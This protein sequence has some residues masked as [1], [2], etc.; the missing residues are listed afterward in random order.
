MQLRFETFNAFNHTNLLDKNIGATVTGSFAFA[1]PTDP[2]TITKNSNFG[3]YSDTDG[4]EV[5][6]WSS[7][8]PTFTSDS[9][10]GLARR[11]CCGLRLPFHTSQLVA[12]A[13]DSQSRL[14]FLGDFY[15]IQ[16]PAGH[17]GRINSYMKECGRFS[18]T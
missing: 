8:A 16:T 2:L 4:P 11:S 1:N 6:A 14:V 17:F 18:R 5:F 12:S 9:P 13:F 10:R 3:T 15:V 7:P